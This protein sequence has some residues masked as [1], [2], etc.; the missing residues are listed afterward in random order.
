MDKL[1]DNSYE[2]E[3]PSIYSGSRKVPMHADIWHSKNYFIF[4]ESQN[5]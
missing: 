5:V 3:K 2:K 1:L 4:R